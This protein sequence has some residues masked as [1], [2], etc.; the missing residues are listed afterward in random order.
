MTALLAFGAIL[1]TLGAAYCA[2]ADG[3]LLAVDDDDPLPG[4]EVALLI[5]RRE[6]AHRAL[7]F[8]RI[9]SQLVAGACSV[10]AL[11][12][13]I[14]PAIQVAPLVVVAGMLVV[15]I[16]ES[17]ARVA[18]DL[19]AA[20]GLVRQVRG[21]RM[22]ES[23]MA[24]VVRLGAAADMLLNAMLPLGNDREAEH[25][26]SVEQFREVVTADA[27]LSADDAKLLRGVF[28]LGD[29]TVQD[30]MVPRV[31]VI[32]LDRRHGWAD[33]LSRVRAAHHARYPVYEQTMDNVVGIL[34]AKDLL[35][36]VLAG[37]EPEGGWQ[38]M[39]RPAQFIPATKPVDDQ[40]RDF[41]ELSRHM[42]IVADEFGG[43][44]G[45]V[46]LED[47]LEVIVGE[48]RD[49]HDVEEPEIRR[50]DGR[51][52]LS[53]RVTLDELGVI[54]GADFSRQGVH[55]LGG[56]VY[57]VVGGVPRQGDTVRVGAWRLT[58]Q[59]V[60]KRRI[61]RVAVEVEPDSP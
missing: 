30:I 53:G 32:G 50:E 3:A 5:G 61:V 13:S 42:A 8:A 52:S 23:V 37:A 2:F 29:T 19:A 11:K 40:L 20:E 58:V 17:A 46:T 59:R 6:R 4:P 21:I 31:D 22:I 34:H 49:E 60:A 14:V 33:V 9:V 18:G 45:I 39:V 41:K 7:A 57:A 28:S 15:V 26:T 27:D 10:A 36:S 25:E 43:T 54:T 47:A 24:P 12:A 35:D 16:S 44:A 56:L 1:A 38:A 48:I 55:T 51:I